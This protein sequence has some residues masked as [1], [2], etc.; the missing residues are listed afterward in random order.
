MNACSATTP[1][2]GNSKHCGG[3]CGRVTAEHAIVTVDGVF[4]AQKEE[5]PSA[6]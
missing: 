5:I 4:E 1:S 6:P 2:R 3:R